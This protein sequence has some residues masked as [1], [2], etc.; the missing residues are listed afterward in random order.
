MKY[1][2]IQCSNGNFN[3]NAET[4]NI[5]TAKVQY[6][7]D[8]RNL[9]NTADVYT[10]SVAIVDEKF[11]IYSDDGGIYKATISHDRPQEE[12]QEQPQGE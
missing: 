2:V 7:G 12:Q 9:Q 6:F 1:S 10:G 8:C 11:G 3:I 5:N 4:E